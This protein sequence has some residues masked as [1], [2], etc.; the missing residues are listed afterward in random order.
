MVEFV[1]LSAAL[2]PFQNV[3]SAYVRNPIAWAPGGVLD[4]VLVH[5]ICTTVGMRA[6]TVM[7]PAAG[8]ITVGLTMLVY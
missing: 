8:L 1:H 6:G 7:C 5:S 2:E 4:C 3:G